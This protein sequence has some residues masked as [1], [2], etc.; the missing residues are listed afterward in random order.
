[1][2]QIWISEFA[3][4]Q[5]ADNEGH[6][7]FGIFYGLMLFD[8]TTLLTGSQIENMLKHEIKNTKR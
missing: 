1:M 5:T 7:Y 6:L 3:D 2:F 4:K 8:Q